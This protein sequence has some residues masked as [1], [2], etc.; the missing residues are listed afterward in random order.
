MECDCFPKDLCC[1]GDG[2]NGPAAAAA[3][4]DRDVWMA[5]ASVFAGDAL[6]LVAYMLTRSGWCAVGGAIWAFGG[7]GLLVKLPTL[8]APPRFNP[9]EFTLF[10]GLGVAGATLVAVALLGARE[11]H[12]L[13]ARELALGG[14]AALVWDS[15]QLCAVVGI[16]LLGYAPAVAVWSSVII[17]VS[18]AWGVCAFGETPSSLALS[19]TA[20]AL[21][22]MGIAAVAWSVATAGDDSGVEHDATDESGDDRGRRATTQPSPAIGL[23]LAVICG[24][25]SGSLMMPL[26]YFT[27]SRSADDE[28]SAG[29]LDDALAYAGAFAIGLTIV[30]PTLCGGY[31][32][33]AS[34]YCAA[35]HAD[36]A[37]T[38]PTTEPAGAS[39]PLLVASSAKA[40]APTTGLLLVPLAGVATGVL[41][42]AANLLSI[43][44]TIALGDAVGYTLTQVGVVVAGVWGVG[45]FGEVQTRERRIGFALGLLIIVCG[46]FLLGFYG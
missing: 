32:C 41:W 46:S 27:L 36:S 2:L 17:A 31:L 33:A 15:S 30:T 5:A 7:V 19:L 38:E 39:E 44:A 4:T 34:Y 35:R 8:T 3:L 37:V 21:L 6:F 20:L 26:H 43:F 18:F 23:A 14:A 11:L 1:G 25:L 16:G 29:S 10:N 22:A 9:V 24:V 28:T 40:G 45:L 12:T 42:A 13:D